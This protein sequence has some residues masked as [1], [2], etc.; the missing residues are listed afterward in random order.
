[1][2]NQ[3]AGAQALDQV[4]GAQALDQV[5]GAQALDQVAGYQVIDQVVG[6]HT[7]SG[8]SSDGNSGNRW[9]IVSALC[10]LMPLI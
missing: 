2:V 8:G 10:T 3:V 4:A 9:N 6:A 5:T 1:M 7:C